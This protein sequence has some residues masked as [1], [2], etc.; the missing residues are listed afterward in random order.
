MT[1]SVPIHFHCNES[2]SVT[3]SYFLLN[4]SLCVSHRIESNTAFKHVNEIEFWVNYLFKLQL[5]ASEP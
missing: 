3:V 2:E 4:I 5:W 1:V